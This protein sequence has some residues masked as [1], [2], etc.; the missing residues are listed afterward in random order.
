MVLVN[1]KLLDHFAR[2]HAST[3]KSL[4]TWRKS[5]EEGDWKKKQDV[6][7]SFPNAKM[8]KSNRARFEIQHN[9]Y[10][11]I[12]EIFYEKTIVEVRFAGTHNEY[13]K[14]DPLTV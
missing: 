2:D 4:A 1:T 11:L 9:K 14:I 13:E 7:M 5:V 10:R 12:A 8:L 3:K 6:L